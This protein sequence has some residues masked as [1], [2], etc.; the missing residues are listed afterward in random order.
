MGVRLIQEVLRHSPVDLSTPQRLLLVVLAE[1]AN[2]HTRVCFPGMDVLELHTGFSERMVRK[3]LGQLA[4]RGMD[5]RVAHGTDKIGRPVYSS[6]GHRTTYRIPDLM[7]SN[8]GTSGAAIP[9]P[10]GGTTGTAFRDMEGGT[11]GGTKAVPGGRN[12]G[13]RGTAL[14]SG[15]VREPSS[16][17]ASTQEPTDDE[18]DL[19]IDHLEHLTGKRP[20]RGH[21]RA[22]VGE[23]FG[24]AGT[25]VAHPMRYLA[26][27]FERATPRDIARWTPTAQP[28]PFQ[29]ESA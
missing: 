1:S 17:R 24:R 10:E 26:A 8:G 9:A 23:I 15:T 18:I 29:R 2:D 14:P 6:R 25:G 27:A 3:V 19:A 20:D 16:A 13:T 12:G 4:E 28:P 5:V 7:P 21:A 22:V 11:W